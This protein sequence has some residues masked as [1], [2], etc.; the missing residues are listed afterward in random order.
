MDTEGLAQSMS[1]MVER[2]A[3]Q[4]IRQYGPPPCPPEEF[5]LK[6]VEKMELGLSRDEAEDEVGKEHSAYYWERYPDEIR[7]WLSKPS[8]WQELMS[9]K[10][11]S[12]KVVE[13]STISI[14]LW[15]PDAE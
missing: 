3:R 4:H 5:Y 7:E 9:G 8:P 15:K 12:A 2:F 14:P 6:V 13:G 10:T 1:G 11:W